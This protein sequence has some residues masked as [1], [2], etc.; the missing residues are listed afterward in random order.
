MN[1]EEI[2]F[3]GLVGPTHNFGGLSVGNVKS[4]ENRGRVSNPRA[5]ALQGLAKMRLLMSLGLAQGVLP[6]HERPHIPSL[7]RLGFIGSDAQVLEAASKINHTLVVNVSSASSMWAANAATV[8]P[9]ADTADG[10]VHITPANLSTM[11]HRSLESGFATRIF[12]TVFADSAH[13]V[14]HDPLPGGGKFGDEGAANHSRLCALHAKPGVE[15]FVF[16]RSAFEG[17]APPRR[18]E[19]RQALE[20]SQSVARMH[21]LDPAKTLFV[22]QAQ[23]AIDAGAFHNDV[24][25]VA[26][27]PLLLAHEFAFEKDSVFD[28]IRK[29]CPFETSLIA[30]RESDVPLAEA[31]QCYFFNSQLV[32][33]PGDARD[34]VLVL[35]ED[36]K[37]S[38]RALAFARSLVAGGSPIGDLA[39]TDIRQSMRNGG[40][41]ACLRLRVVLTK[42][43]RDA[44]RGRALL[45]ESGLAR[46]EDW[47]RRRYRDRLTSSDLGDPVLMEEGHAALDE[48]TGILDL[49]SIY[50]FQT[51]GSGAASRLA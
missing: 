3:D 34:M 43:E 31:L 50:E 15:V 47:V 37:A 35:P 49:G 33:R 29:A 14:I 46:L 9:S 24:A 21:V 45:D 40:G 36:V 4:I 20:A 8:S 12:R 1:A 27:G 38:P 13:F 39:F 22:Q 11:F 30:V 10:R 5:A 7:R 48:L 19:P 2:N 26:N 25:A 18:F 17:G 41:P 44:L 16:G 28:A 23:K 32:T 6:P 42:A 51:A